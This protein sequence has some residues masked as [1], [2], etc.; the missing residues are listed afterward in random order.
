[1]AS[2]RLF[3]VRERLEEEGVA[4]DTH[5]VAEHKVFREVPEILTDVEH[6]RRT[7]CSRVE[8]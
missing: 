7:I 5:V 1:M 4:E 6:Y 2:G 3:E 8:L